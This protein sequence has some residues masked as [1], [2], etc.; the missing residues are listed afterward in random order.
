MKIKNGYK[1][2]TIAGENIVIDYGKLNV[3]MTKVIALN[4]TS[5]FLWNK[6]IDRSFGVND[7]VDTLLAEYEVERLQATEDAEKWILM[8][9][10][11]ELLDE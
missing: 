7:I 3:S 10:K 8:M 9:Q 5:L 11:A 2:R 6:L 1:I 4:D